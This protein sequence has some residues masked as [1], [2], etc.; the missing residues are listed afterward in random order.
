MAGKILPYII[1]GYVQVTIVL[2]AALVLFDVPMLGSYFDLSVGL[3]I[4]IAA[5]LSV[6]FTISTVARNQLQAMQ[7]TIFFFL[8]SILLS[9]F[10]FPFR[11][12]PIWAQ[13]V[14]EVL[15]NTH[16]MRI[17]R[18]IMLKGSGLVELFGDVWPLLA[19][20]MAAIAIALMRYRRTLD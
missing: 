12:M 6:G 1:V 3:A 11:G 18:G 8:P 5:N 4:F 19:F 10:M 7:M 9:G 2:V 16:F 15:P 20:M 14:G 17:V 13:W